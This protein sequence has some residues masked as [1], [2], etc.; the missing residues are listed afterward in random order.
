MKPVT[1][2]FLA[3]LVLWPAGLLADP[4]TDAKIRDAALSSYNL[5][6]VLENRVDVEV[7][8]GVATISG[9]VLDR[10]Q[11]A[12]AEDTVRSLPSVVEVLNHLDV[13]EPG[14]ERSDGWIALKLRSILLLRR[15]VSATNTEVTVKD[16]VVTLAGMADSVAQKELTESYARGIQGVRS[17]RNLMSLPAGGMAAARVEEETVKIDDASITAEIR[18][19][20]LARDPGMA[21]TTR[22]ETD[23][24]SVV[25]RG[26][27]RSVA[28]RDSVTELASGVRGVNTVANEMIVTAA[29]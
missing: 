28:E 8:D 6:V 29:E 26:S 25:L 11:K 19:A 20:L 17:V 4:A 14:Q 23:G 16:G 13:A 21:L 2:R 15:S 10:D 9:T 18:Q 12:L 22:V 5:R 24:G 1:C 3:L 7:K 27:A